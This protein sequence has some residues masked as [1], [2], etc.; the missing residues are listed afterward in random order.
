LSP[1]HEKEFSR[2]L[3]LL[4]DVNQS[5]LET[6]KLCVRLLD[7]FSASVRNPAEWKEM[8]SM[9]QETIAGAEREGRPIEL[10]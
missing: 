5:L 2:Y 4:E 1:E 9:F 10:H 3:S 6:L 8:R 7:Q